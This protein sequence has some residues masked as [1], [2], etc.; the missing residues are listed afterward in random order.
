MVWPRK[1]RALRCIEFH[2]SGASVHRPPNQI[3]SPDPDRA[4]RRPCCKDDCIPSGTSA[5]VQTSF[6]STPSARHVRSPG[7]K[8]KGPGLEADTLRIVRSHTRVRRCPSLPVRPTSGI[9]IS[10]RR[11]YCNATRPLSPRSLARAATQ[12]HRRGI[13]PL[14]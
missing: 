5:G 13:L 10:R 11:D 7:T 9:V 4:H 3:F 2:S 1:G 14:P 6:R 12:C 8:P